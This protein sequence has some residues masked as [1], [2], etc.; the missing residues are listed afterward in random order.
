[1][2]RAGTACYS[3][4]YNKKWKA[5]WRV[6]EDNQHYFKWGLTAFLTLLALLFAVIIL[7]NFSGVAASFRALMYILSPILYGFAFAYLLNP[8][9]RAVEGGLGKLLKKRG[10]TERRAA[11]AG[12]IVGILAALAVVVLL[13]WAFIGTVLPQLV[14]TISGIVSNLSGYYETAHT[15]LTRLFE[16]Q[17]T[18]KGYAD[19]VLARFYEWLENWMKND[20][21]S[22]VQKV[23]VTVTTSLFSVV[24]W[25][26]FVVVGLIISVYLL[27]SR[28]RFLAQAKK[29]VIAIW[30]PARADRILQLSRRANRIFG[31]FI[32]GKIL[33]SL[34]IGVLCFIGMSILRLPY[35]VLIATIVGVTN[36]IPVFGPY[37]GAI[38]SAILILFVSPLQCLYFII[39]VLVLQQLDGNVIGPH[40]LGDATGLT[41]F[42]VVVSI[43]VA[44]GLFGFT[45]M[46]LGVPAFAFLYALLADIINARLDKKGLDTRTDRY[47]GVRAVADVTD[48]P[49]E[50]EEVPAQDA[51]E[52]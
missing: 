9:V 12:R 38:P 49:D 10:V 30:K 33:D 16:N 21:T 34:I 45:G 3:K 4:L 47:Y 17:P 5:G 48:A 19:T 7:T 29:C 46:L 31:G 41:G 1:M 2:T 44:G 11:L 36:V 40:I 18:L 32:R 52:K 13:I 20:L 50:P 15:W 25:V 26:M 14:D 23:M 8:I 35:P 42:W 28:D 37:I 39:F 22:T 6:R 51:P 43:T 27:A 24:K